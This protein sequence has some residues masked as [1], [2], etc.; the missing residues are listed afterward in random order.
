[1]GTISLQLDPNSQTEQ[2]SDTATF[3]P[4]NGSGVAANV[5]WDGTNLSWSFG[6]APSHTTYDGGQ[7]TQVGNQS[8]NPI[9]PTKFQHTPKGPTATSAGAW[10]A[11]QSTPNK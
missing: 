6:Q 9:V 3:T 11:T 8:S 4:A 1:M 5:T 10:T 2:L 7:C